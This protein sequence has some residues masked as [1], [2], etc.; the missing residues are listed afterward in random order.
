[1]AAY[2]VRPMGEVEIENAASLKDAAV[3]AKRCLSCNVFEVVEVTSGGHDWRDAE[4]IDL[5]FTEAQE[6][7]VRYK[8]SLKRWL[9]QTPEGWQAL[10]DK[11]GPLAGWRDHGRPDPDRMLL[12]EITELLSDRGYH[13]IST[14][15]R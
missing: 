6:I 13:A 9:Y 4:I 15:E 2:R 8:S 12:E 1:M 3:Q 11:D 7:A 14:T 5:G 10:T